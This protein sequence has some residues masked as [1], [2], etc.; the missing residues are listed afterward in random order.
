[1]SKRAKQA[2][3]ERVAQSNVVAAEEALQKARVEA[4]EQGR[5]A[6]GERRWKLAT[7]CGPALSM[8][9]LDGRL[10]VVTGDGSFAEIDAGDIDRCAPS[11]ARASSM[12]VITSPVRGEV[13]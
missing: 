1:M 4:E 9:Y 12:P 6:K 8:Q 5:D 11:S 7:G 10:Y 13:G 2:D 3:E